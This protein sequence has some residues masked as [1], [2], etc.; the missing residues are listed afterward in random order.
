MKWILIGYIIVAGDTGM[1]TLGTFA[2]KAG[3]E[4]TGE[5]FRA[6]GRGDKGL[7][8]WR[9][10]E[11]IPRADEARLLELRKAVEEKQ[12]EVLDLGDE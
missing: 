9:W 3:C 1:S 7:S 11:C 4:A 8:R 6:T 12:D 2:T 10:S 5:A